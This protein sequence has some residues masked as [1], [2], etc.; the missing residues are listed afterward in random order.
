MVANQLISTSVT[1][2]TK[3]LQK[4]FTKCCI[5]FIGSLQSY[6]IGLKSVGIWGIFS[7]TLFEIDYFMQGRISTTQGEIYR[8]HSLLI[9]AR[10]EV[11][12][13]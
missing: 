1:F 6:H 4:A 12:R 13:R 8:S 7:M 5:I 3:R 9:T 2:Q 10:S 11:A